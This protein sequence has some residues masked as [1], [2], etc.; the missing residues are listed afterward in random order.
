MRLYCMSWI[1]QQ[2]GL[3]KKSRQCLMASNVLV[4]SAYRHHLYTP[5][6]THCFA[7]R[8]YSTTFFVRA[9]RRTEDVQCA[10]RFRHSSGS[11]DPSTSTT[12]DGRAGAQHYWLLEGVALQRARLPPSKT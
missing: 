4:S 6:N 11:I 1:G 12:A 8:A 3:W 10:I 9:T 2:T 5:V 7:T